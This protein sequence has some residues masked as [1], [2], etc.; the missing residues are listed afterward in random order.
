MQTQGLQATEAE[1]AAGRTAPR[2]SLS[3]IEANIAYQV[4]F[5]A[6]SA[7]GA[8]LGEQEANTPGI[9][10]GNTLQEAPESLRVLTIHL[11]VLRNGFTIIGKSAPADA[12][13]F[14]DE[15]GRK[16]AYEDAVR[17]VWPLMGYALREKV[18]IAEKAVIEPGPGMTRYLGTKVVNAVPMS[19]ADYNE[20]REW[21]LPE[22]EDG[23]DAGFL[24]EYADE[25]RPNT[26]GFKGYVSWSPADV[27]T[28][29]YQP[30]AA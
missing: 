15:L 11:M 17:Q 24:V 19:R 7:I 29:A 2:V 13:N 1:C 5:V 30:F 20:L 27:F 16:L 14:D 12:R 23:T 9:I 18:M 28:R 21:Q 6:S 10:V 4:A 25:Q 3:D 26:P 8:L 22:N